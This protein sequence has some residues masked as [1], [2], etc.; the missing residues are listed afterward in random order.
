MKSVFK[1]FRHINNAINLIYKLDKS[2]T[3][4]SDN[5]KKNHTASILAAKALI[6]LNRNKAFVKSLH[7]VEFQVFS[8][9]GDDGII[10]FLIHKLNLTSSSFIEFGV[11]NYTESNTRFLL[12][13][14][15]WKGLILDGSETNIQYIL[16]DEIYWK[17]SL[18]AKH[19]F[20]TAE[21]INSIIEEAGFKDEIGLLSI[22]IDG[23]DYYVW[24]AINN[25]SPQLVIIE[26]N[27]LFGANLPYT[28]PY[29][30]DFIRAQQ[31]LE[32]IFYGSS[33]TSL[34]DLATEKGY[35]FIG[36]NNAGN[37]AYF[38]RNDKLAQVGLPSL[39][40]QEGFVEAKFREAFINGNRVGVAEN[41]NYFENFTVYN[42]RSQ[43]L[44]T[45]GKT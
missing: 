32:K 18:T 16:N 41:R 7:E 13:N 15:N 19:A 36:C 3:E 42:T 33:L 43:K 26:Y 30:A 28:I 23:N 20:I 8:Q 25:I 39:R 21:N 2:L 40:P 10:Q 37:N 14:N 34:F 22:D 17:H 12:I 31:G 44:Q 45:Y 6:E 27:S 35:S 11:E 24:K 4:L 1:K 9:W 5:N 38:I 29:K